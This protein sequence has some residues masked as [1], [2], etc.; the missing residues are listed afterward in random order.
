[1]DFLM[2]IQTVVY[3]RLAFEPDSFPSDFLLDSS[4]IDSSSSTEDETEEPSEATPSEVDTYDFEFEARAEREVQ[5]L[6]N[7]KE[8]PLTSLK[9]GP[10]A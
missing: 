4:R 7:P 3:L 9:P 6:L 5:E 1:M 10:V 2:S 8:K